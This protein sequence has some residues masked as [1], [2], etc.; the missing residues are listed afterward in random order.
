ML[1]NN[2]KSTQKSVKF[3][4][5]TGRYPNLCGGFLVLNIEGYYTSLVIA[6]KISHFGEVV[7]SVILMVFHKEN[8]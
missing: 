8:G 6:Q 3:V 7:V 2:I 4:S 5:Y 1:A